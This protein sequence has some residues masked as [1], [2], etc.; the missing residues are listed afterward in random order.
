MVYWGFLTMGKR[1]GLWKLGHVWCGIVTWTVGNTAD[2]N[3]IGLENMGGLA[4][5]VFLGMVW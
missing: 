3:L 2:T 5:K 1:R 4:G